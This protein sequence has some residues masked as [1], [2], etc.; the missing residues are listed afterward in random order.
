MNKYEIDDIDYID[1]SLGPCNELGAEQKLFAAVL[2]RAVLDLYSSEYMVEK[3]MRVLVYPP[4]DEE[5][6]EA[7]KTLGGDGF[8]GGTKPFIDPANDP[9][10]E[11]SKYKKKRAPT[12]WVKGLMYLN[13]QQA[14]KWWFI[15]W[16]INGGFKKEK[17]PIFSF[18]WICAALGIDPLAIFLQLEK[19]QLF[20]DD[21][22]CF[23]PMR[24]PGQGRKRGPKP[25]VKI[26]ID[27]GEG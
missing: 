14:A 17:Y 25:S 22:P 26:S 6:L 20:G 19:K 4:E 1:G 7:Y 2:M 5:S 21:P 16:Y 9:N 10:C 8:Y 18:P 3:G 11:M 27:S 13:C 15:E 12:R 24:K 23:N